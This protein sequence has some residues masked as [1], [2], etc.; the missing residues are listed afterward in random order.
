MITNLGDRG[1]GSR[2]I[3]G[4]AD[5]CSIALIGSIDE[6]LGEEGVSLSGLGGCQRNERNF[7]V[8]E[9]HFDV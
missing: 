2:W 6:E 5:A 4:H 8:G 3:T 7:S 1:G 9:L